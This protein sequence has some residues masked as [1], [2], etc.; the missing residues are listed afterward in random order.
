M[1]LPVD[2]RYVAET[3]LEVL[4]T[5]EAIAAIEAEITV[6]QSQGIAKVNLTPDRAVRRRDHGSAVGAT[7]A[8]A[9]QEPQ[10]VGDDQQARADV[11]GD[12]HPEVGQ[13]EDGQ[14][15][16]DDLGHEC[17]RDVLADPGERGAAVADEPGEPAEVVGEENDIGGSR[18]RP[19][20]RCLPARC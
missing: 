5:P 15:Q 2:G 14:D 19:R 9:P 11:G 13:P 16:Y 6:L 7:R 10:G 8:L 17:E 12:G 1:T 18:S 20:W 4:T 3:T